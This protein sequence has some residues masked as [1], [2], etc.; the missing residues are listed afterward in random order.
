MGPS[1]SRMAS[2]L[3]RMILSYLRRRLACSS[4]GKCTRYHSQRMKYFEYVGTETNRPLSIRGV[5]QQVFFLPHRCLFL[6]EPDSFLSLIIL[7]EYS[8]GG[9]QNS[10]C[11]AVRNGQGCTGNRTRQRLGK[12]RCRMDFWACPLQ[13]HR[14]SF[15]PVKCRV[16][17]RSRIH[18]DAFPQRD[19]DPKTRVSTTKGFSTGAGCMRHKEELETIRQ[20]FRLKPDRSSIVNSSESAGNH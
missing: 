10:I 13:E 5:P 6:G 14:Q 2:W 17:T 15:G 12:S 11:L 9:V 7:R 19:C 4:S 3:E 18:F 8:S 20:H 1:V 16:A